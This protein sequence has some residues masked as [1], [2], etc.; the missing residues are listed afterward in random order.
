MYSLTEKYLRFSKLKIFFGCSFLYF[1]E[2]LYFVNLIPLIS[3]WSWTM[4]TARK[5]TKA[6]VGLY[7]CT[8]NFW[9]LSRYI[10][11]Q[12]ESRW[13]DLFMTFLCLPLLTFRRHLLFPW[14]KF[15]ASYSVNKRRDNCIIRLHLRKLSKWYVVE[16][17]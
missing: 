10:W 15:F 9:V 13:S 6:Q 17:I 3:W 7:S 12:C 5:S 11:L 16:C 2:S 4:K 14:N 8:C 1:S